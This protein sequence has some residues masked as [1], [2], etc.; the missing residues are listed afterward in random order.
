MSWDTTTSVILHIS[1]NSLGNFKASARFKLLCPCWNFYCEHLL[2]CRWS[3]S[4]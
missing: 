1:H 3:T 2:L 4:T